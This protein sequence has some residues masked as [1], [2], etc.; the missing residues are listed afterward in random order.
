[1]SKNISDLPAEICIRHFRCTIAMFHFLILLALMT[2]GELAAQPSIPAGEPIDLTMLAGGTAIFSVN[3]AGAAPLRYQ[4]RRYSVNNSYT[5]IPGATNSTLILSNAQTT[6][7]QFGVS[8]IDATNGTQLSRQ[9]KL[10]VIPP[11][12]VLPANPA[13]S[14]FADVTFTASITALGPVTYQWFFNGVAVPGAVT[15]TLSVTNIQKENAG[16]YTL[17]AQYTLG[18]TTSKVSRLKIV[19][20]NSTYFFGFSWTATQTSGLDP[21]QYYEQHFSNGPMWPEFI[22]TNLGLPYVESHNYAIGGAGALEMLSQARAFQAPPKPKLSLYFYWVNYDAY[23]STVTNLAA[24]DHIIQSQV[25]SASNVVNTLYMRGARQ[26]VIQDSLDVAKFPFIW[27][28]RF[29]IVDIFG[30]NAAGRAIYSDLVA[31]E[32]AALQDAVKAFSESKPDSRIIWIDSVTNLNE[33]IANPDRFGFTNSTIPAL[34]DPELNKQQGPV[35][36][37]G[38][39][40]DYVFWDDVHGTTKLHKLITEWALNTITNAVLEVLDA[41]F[42]GNLPIIQMSHLLIGRDYTLQHSIDLSHW[43]DVQTFTATDGTNQI[44]QT[45]TGENKVFYRLQ[46][47]P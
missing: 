22:S 6:P 1:M 32:N 36:F 42:S 3:A 44:P 19:P 15:K 21:V 8:V 14:L 16:D 18:S 10:R 12:L 2:A 24:W 34:L 20:F 40:A 39:G 43:R 23:P 26:I 25:A 9:A 30:T 37:T 17:V 46:W 11:P 33:V 41:R 31:R 45:S 29:P 5:E 47:Q 7:Y 35:S 38:P 4:W 27:P 13:A 28:P